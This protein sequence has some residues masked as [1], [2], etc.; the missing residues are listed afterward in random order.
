MHLMENSF[1]LCFQTYQVKASLCVAEIID[2]NVENK[3]Q[4]YKYA[5]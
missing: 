5:E 3:I 4:V 2:L 1:G